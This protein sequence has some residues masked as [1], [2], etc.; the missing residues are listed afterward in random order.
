[1]TPKLDLFHLKSFLVLSRSLYLK[2]V[3]ALMSKKTHRL[4]KGLI[5]NYAFRAIQD[6]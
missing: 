1:M 2:H 3:N 4:C 6:L 5:K